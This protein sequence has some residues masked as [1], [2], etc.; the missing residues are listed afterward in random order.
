[1][2]FIRTETT[3]PVPTVYDFSPSLNNQVGCPYIL[4]DFA[5]GKPLHRVW[6]DEDRTVAALEQ[7]RTRILQGVA[8][9]MAELS[10]PKF[11]QGG[12]LF[13]D[14]AGRYLGVKAARAVDAVTMFNG[15]STH[16]SANDSDEPGR[17]DDIY[18]AKEPLHTSAS[19]I[20]FGLDRRLNLGRLEKCDRGLD[21]CL[22]LFVQ[23]AIEHSEVKGDEE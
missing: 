21:E 4:M 23:W 12:F 17:E 20:L 15:S 19:S 1:M 22:R 5:Q 10:R 13:F 16:N 7:I 8:S 9:T 2:R 14:D 11:E 18:C 3:V 6:F